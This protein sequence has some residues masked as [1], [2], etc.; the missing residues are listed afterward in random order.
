MTEEEE[1]F[2]NACVALMAQITTP[3]KGSDINVALAVCA[4]CYLIFLRLIKSN[5]THQMKVAKVMVDSVAEIISEEANDA[6]LS[7]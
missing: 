4:E 1:E 5:R 6:P 7:H 2:N 3:L